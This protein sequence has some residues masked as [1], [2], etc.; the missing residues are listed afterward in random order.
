MP[1]RFNCSAGRERLPTSLKGSEK[2]GTRLERYNHVNP[3]NELYGDADD[4][5]EIPAPRVCASANLADAQAD[6]DKNIGTFGRVSNSVAYCRLLWWLSTD[7]FDN[8]DLA[9]QCN[10]WSSWIF[11]HCKRQ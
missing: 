8:F 4:P 2:S 5:L 3:A 9:E 11:T 6:G 10:R 7:A 1:R